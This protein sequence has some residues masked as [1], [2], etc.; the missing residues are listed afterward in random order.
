MSTIRLTLNQSFEEIIQE[1]EEAYKPMSRTEI[2][3]MAVAEFY[4]QRMS[5]ANKKTKNTQLVDDWLDTGQ[6]PDL[7]KGQAEEAFGDWWSQNKTD[8]R[9]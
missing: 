5:Q 2:L 9:N 4:R 6:E 3:K 7:P 8:L 1:L